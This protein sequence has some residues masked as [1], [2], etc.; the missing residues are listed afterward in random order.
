[1]NKAWNANKRSLCTW[2]T[3]NTEEIFLSETN[4]RLFSQRLTKCQNYYRGV[5]PIKEPH[6]QWLK[7]TF[8]QHFKT[9]ERRQ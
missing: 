7:L 3:F 8:K 9:I 4:S 1:M 2:S 5:E 6:K